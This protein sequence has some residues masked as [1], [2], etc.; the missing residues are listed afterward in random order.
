[1]KVKAICTL[2]GIFLLGLTWTFPGGPVPKALGA[3]GS[4]IVLDIP[5]DTALDVPRASDTDTST[6]NAAGEVIAP[7]EGIAPYMDSSKNEPLFLDD[8]ATTLTVP[9]TTEA[10]ASGINTAGKLT[11]ASSYTYIPLD[12]GT[13][14]NTEAY[15]INNANKIVG[16]YWPAPPLPPL[17][18]IPPISPIPTLPII[19]PFGLLDNNDILDSFLYDVAIDKYSPFDVPGASYT[20]ASGINDDGKI[21]GYYEDSSWNRHAFL[22]DGSTSTTLD[23]P[24]GAS[25]ISVYGIN[26]AGQIVGY[27]EDSS[28]EGHGFLYDRAAPTKYTSLDFPGA[29]YISA[30][31]INNAGQIVG[32]YE[33]SSGEG[34]GFLYDGAATP[35][36]TTLDVPGAQHTDAHG[37]NNAGQIVGYYEDSSGEGHGFLYDGAATPKYTT[38][39]VPGASFTSANGIND[40]GKIVGGYADSSW[41]WHGFHT[42]GGSSVNNKPNLTPHQPSRWADKIVVSKEKGTHTNDPVMVGQKVYIDFAFINN[43]KAVAKGGFKN[44]LCIDGSTYYTYTRTGDLAVSSPDSKEDIDWTPTTAGPHT[45]KLICDSANNVN[46]S[47]ES[48]NACS[49]TVQVKPSSV[50]NK[51][52]LTPYQPLG[53]ADKIVVSIKEGTHTNDPIMVGQPVYIDFAYINKG[54][55]VAKGEFGNKL[56][57]DDYCVTHMRSG[58]VEVDGTGTGNEERTF[59]T[60]GT[61]TIKLTCDSD[62][63]VDESDE[64][65][66][67]YSITVEVTTPSG[68]RSLDFGNHTYAYGIN[69]A[70]KIVGYY[71]SGCWA[72][73]M[74]DWY[75]FLYDVVSGG[76]TTLDFSDND[77]MSGDQIT[78]A[79]GINDS[80]KIVGYYADRSGGHGFLCDGATNKPIPLD[81][82]GASDTSANGINNA[83]KIVGNYYSDNSESED[84]SDNHQQHGFLYDEK[85]PKKYTPLDF[86][87]ATGTSAD[88]INNADKIVGDYQD[89]SGKNHGFL[90]DKTAPTLYTPLNFPGAAE[91]GANGINDTDQIVGWYYV[92]NS[93]NRQYHGF[94]YDVAT[95]KYTSLDFADAQHTW[96]YGINNAGQIVGE[97]A[98]SSWKWHGFYIAGGSSVNKPNLTPYKPSEWADKIVVSTK[99]GTHT[100]DPIT[101]GQQVYIDYAYINNGKAVAKGGFT[102]ELCI[103]GNCTA[104]WRSGDVEVKGT[105]AGNDKKWTPTTAGTHTIKLT[106]DSGNDVEESDESDNTYSITV[107]VT[108]S[109]DDK[110]NLTPYQPSGWSNKIVISTKKD[111]HT[112]D[113]IKV[114]Q[115]VYID[116]AYTN[117]GTAVAKGGFKNK[118]CIDGRD[119]LLYMRRDDVAAKGTAT[120]L[121]KEWTFTTAGQ[122]TIELT[123]DSEDSV[124]ESN[125]SDNTYSI[126]VQVSVDLIE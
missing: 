84:S 104:Y 79:Y 29:S 9:G 51:P 19:E 77:I 43:G 87:N 85:A 46:E 22:Y 31:G 6:S 67:T 36:Y 59:T 39:D 115:P 21:V 33:D 101:V 63:D 50:D 8:E 80:G 124:D 108:S 24:S 93:G 121:D 82:S 62:N 73:C 83:G 113:P 58:D 12:A 76:Y 116:Y 98:D 114:N 17:P 34:H 54:K 35:K 112:N 27:Y 81:F 45:I 32:Y 20:L 53:W 13:S 111:I 68:T 117:N 123:C 40:A 2:I 119:V 69:N 125:E 95:K 3:S 41:N 91:T 105:G 122:H 23:G 96:A 26:N 25:Y 90:Y 30:Y 52:N 107:Q 88:G 66:N 60:A 14:G 110:P 28:G 37:I 109:V 75:G 55:A 16:Q 61:H 106:C 5:G 86:P 89:S 42:A 70:G 92:D 120:G 74:P 99:E 103:D 56:C 48:D 15:G 44:E 7:Y 65:D 64:S 1:M 72:T 118:L 97:Y 57:I 71:E 78:R 126:T 4:N 18:P 102:N 100:N 38:L 49:I 94:L 10:D 11:A 47:D